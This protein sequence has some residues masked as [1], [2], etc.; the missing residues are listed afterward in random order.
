VILGQALPL[1]F[2]LAAKGLVRL[3]F[4]VLICLPAK[5]ATPLEHESVVAFR[6]VVM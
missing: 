1:A 6:P 5:P 2:S 3:V 4:G